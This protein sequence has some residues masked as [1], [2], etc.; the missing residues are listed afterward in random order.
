MV[1][2]TATG[3]V[4]T[5]CGSHPPISGVD[6]A[7]VAS[8]VE[9][10]VDLAASVAAASVAAEPEAA[11]EFYP[12]NSLIQEKAGHTCDARPYLLENEIKRLP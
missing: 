3:T 1:A 2:A 10:E 8:A 6:P 9:A 4:R 7:A 5:P 12:V 11:G